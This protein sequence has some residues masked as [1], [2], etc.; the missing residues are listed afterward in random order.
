MTNPNTLL[1]QA[2]HGPSTPL[3]LSSLTQ[4]QLVQDMSTHPTYWIVEVEAREQWIDNSGGGAVVPNMNDVVSFEPRSGLIGSLSWANLTGRRLF[5][6]LGTTLRLCVWARRVEFSVCGPTGRNG[7]RPAIPGQPLVVGDRVS[8]TQVNGQ[9]SAAN[10]CTDAGWPVPAGA[11][12]LR[13]GRL[14]LRQVVAA[15]GAA[16]TI[17]LPPGA[18]GLQI[19][20]QVPPA[21]PNP[22]TPWTFLDRLGDPIGPVPLAGGTSNRV[23]VPGS[24]NAVRLSAIPLVTTTYTLAFELDW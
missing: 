16:P 22:N 17:D 4:V 2:A 5:F 11:L 8:L 13:Q 7:L 19:Y 18:T 12:G 6:D 14:T 24:A 23:I 21:G 1:L 9:A 15:G 3:P 10:G 20:E